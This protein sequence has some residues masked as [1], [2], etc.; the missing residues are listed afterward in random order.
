MPVD[1]LQRDFFAR[2]LDPQAVRTVF[3][4]VPGVFF[5]MK[6]CQGRFIAANQA[7]A[8]RYGVKAES[9]LVGAT[10]IDF[11]PPEIAKAYREDDLKV[12]ESGLP[13]VNRLEL[14]YDEQHGL[15]WFLTTKLPVFDKNRHVIGV[16]GVVRRDEKRM[17]HRDVVEVR[18]AID[19]ARRHCHRTAT[20]AELAVHVG[21]SERQLCRILDSALGV[22]PYELLL[23]TRIQSAAE[24]LATSSQPIVEIA[25]H[26]GFCDQSA[27]TLQF[28]KRIG[29]TPREFRQG[30][31]G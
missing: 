10:D 25:V 17:H 27:F 3:E 18:T 23:R 16:M 5:F 30:H 28:R 24:A 19:F 21:V 15:D 9:E 31:M 7:T 11:V 4:H 2:I 8:L 12:I 1:Q 22:S 20:T 14:F 6:D 13:L 29:M 26:H